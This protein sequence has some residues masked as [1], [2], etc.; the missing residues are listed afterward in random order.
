MRSETLEESLQK[1]KINTI[2]FDSFIKADSVLNQKGYQN[3]ACAISGGADS[4][5]ILDI[6]ERVAPNKTTYV[7]FDTGLEYQATK[8]HLT[9]LEN[10]YGVQI[11]RQRAKTPVPLGVKTY[12]APFLSKFVSEMMSRLQQHDFDWKDRPYEEQLN[13]FDRCKSAMKWFSNARGITK[14]HKWD[15]KQNKWLREFLIENPPDFQVSDMCCKGAKKDISHEFVKQNGIDLLILGI[16]KAE[17]GVRA[18]AYKSCFNENAGT[19]FP[20]FWYTNPDRE[21]YEQIF[22][23]NHSKCYTEY[24]LKRTGCAGCPFGRDFESELRI[25]EKYEPQL[26]KACNYI[27]G[28]SYEYTRKYQEFRRKMEEL[29][30][31]VS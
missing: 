7:W 22:N 1:A 29:K 15:I 8:D 11:I 31:K 4:D 19:Y 23:I 20:I 2:I 24:G 16:R 27:F 5:I 28:K 3:I 26:Y 6:C 18:G 30:S 13:H 21:E 10:R 12:G 25:I 9:Y 14:T 17:G